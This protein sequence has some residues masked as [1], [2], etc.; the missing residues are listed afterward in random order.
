MITN[1]NTQQSGF[2]MHRTDRTI[3]LIAAGFLGT[4]G[5]IA[6]T[7][8]SAQSQAP[9]NA[10][11]LPE[12]PGR[13]LVAQNCAQ[14]HPIG[15]ALGKRRTPA[16]WNAQLLNMVARGAQLDD[17]Q[18]KLAQQYLATHFASAPASGAVVQAAAAQPTVPARSYPRPSGPSQ[19][20]AYGGGNA[21]QNFSPFTQVT[22]ANV[23]KLTPAWTYHYGAGIVPQGDQG[24]DYRF[25][26]T[27]LIVGGIM[28]FST[29]SSPASPNLKASI[30]ALRP[31][32]G[33]LIWKYD[34]PLNIHG[35]GIAY[36]PGDAETAPRIIFATDGGLIMAVDVTTGR[37]AP[38][39]G[40]GGQIDAYVGVASEVVGESRRSSFTIPNPV[41]IHKNLFITGSRPGED[42]PPGP[43]GDIRAFDV[44]TGRKVWEFHTIP[45]PGEPGSDQWPGTSWRDVTGANVW[46]TMSVDDERGIVYASTGDANV[47]AA[48]GGSQPYASS[49]LALDAA[50]GKLLWSRQITH[51]DVWDWDAPTPMVLMDHVQDG[52]TIPAVLMTGKHGLVFLF[53]RVTGEPLNGVAERPTPQLAKPDPSIWPT[54]PF[55]EWP[56]PIARTQ[57]TRDE[58]PDLVPGMKTACQ[59]TWDQ[60]KTVSGPL[61]TPRRHPDH[62]VV[63]YPS[64]VGGPN[65]GGGAYDPRTGLYYISIQNRVTFSLPSDA[66]QGMGHLTPPAPGTPGANAPPRPRGPRGGRNQPFTFTTPDNITLSCGALPWGEMVAVDMKAKKIAWRVPLGTTEGIGP[67]GLTTGSSN[68]GGTLTTAGG[69]VFVGA[70]NDRRLRALD[71]KTGRKLWETTLDASAA[72]TPISYMGSDG[73]QYVVVAAGGGTSVGQKQMAD[74][75]VAFKL[76]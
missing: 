41:T 54:Q 68:I 48:V 3:S 29:P 20:P 21:N 71:A 36:W 51:Q 25:E 39:F 60:Y 15:L 44:R 19:W 67:K 23:A 53:N 38:G 74:T 42:G 61:Y 72:A 56:E 63:T 49:L 45:H 43:R 32:T 35:R 9:A 2:I 70:T 59:A 18:L 58:I 40:W 5:L 30:T 16:E 26:V 10:L 64:S 14:C 22:T 52:K 47:P 46:S 69:L 31:E 6:L 4:A 34:S 1:C 17:G 37:L 55:P 76:P 66:P 7:A 28:Y 13:D 50:T 11:A 65:W 62:A 57:M 27:P 8:T 24:L 12:G 75:L 73:K 33:E